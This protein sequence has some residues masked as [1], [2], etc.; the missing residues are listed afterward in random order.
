M[1]TETLTAQQTAATTTKLHEAAKDQTPKVQPEKQPEHR[2]AEPEKQPTKPDTSRK[3]APTS[4]QPEKPKTDKVQSTIVTRNKYNRNPYNYS[5]MS[6][7]KATKRNSAGARGGKQTTQ[8]MRDDATQKDGH[9]MERDKQTDKVNDVRNDEAAGNEEHAADDDSLRDEL[10]DEDDEA[11]FGDAHAE[12]IPQWCKDYEVERFKPQPFNPKP[13]A[14]EAHQW[15]TD[16]LFSDLDADP[17]AQTRESDSYQKQ[18]RKINRAMQARQRYRNHLQFELY[19]VRASWMQIHKK[20][21]KKDANTD[22]QDYL[23]HAIAYDDQLVDA[24]DNLDKIRIIFAK[25]LQTLKGELHL[26]NT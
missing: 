24:I 25:E 12:P 10:D 13:N 9:A 16:L 23:A 8:S 17:L 1:A 3:S 26:I 18:I 7:L 5:L 15:I 2:T 21:G 11:V 6:G 19:R 14:Q 20:G 22:L 4:K